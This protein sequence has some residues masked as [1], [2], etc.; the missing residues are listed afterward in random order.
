MHESRVLIAT[1]V[2]DILK[3]LLS[4]KKKPTCTPHGMGGVR[5]TLPTLLR[6]ATRCSTTTLC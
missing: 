5:N 2:S 4:S 3:E 1:E 6:K